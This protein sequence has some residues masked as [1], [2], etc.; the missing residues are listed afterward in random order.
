MRSHSP[1]FSKEGDAEIQ[2]HR[3]CQ[4]QLMTE[5]SPAQSPGAALN[6]REVTR[7]VFTET[8]WL[9]PT[10]PLKISISSA[11]PGENKPNLVLLGSAGA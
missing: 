9:S 6:L 1:R 7:D 4:A 10:Q 11:L 8:A 3:L 5:E 2:G